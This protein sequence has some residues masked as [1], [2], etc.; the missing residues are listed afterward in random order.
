MYACAELIEE[1][2]IPQALIFDRHGYYYAYTNLPPRCIFNRDLQLYFKTNQ[3]S[4]INMVYLII[5]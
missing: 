2:R 5:G 3:N 1:T 4:K